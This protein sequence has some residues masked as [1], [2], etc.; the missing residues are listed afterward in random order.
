MGSPADHKQP[1]DHKQA[2]T[3]PAGLLGRVECFRQRSLRPLVA[4]IAMFRRTVHARALPERL[5]KRPRAGCNKRYPSRSSSPCS[6]PFEPELGEKQS[7]L[8]RSGPN[9]ARPLQQRPV[10]RRCCP[11]T[12]QSCQPRPPGVDRLTLLKP[13]PPVNP[14]KVQS[15]RQAAAVVLNPAALRPAPAARTHRRSADR[16]AGPT[17]SDLG[18]APLVPAP[19]ARHCTSVAGGTRVPAP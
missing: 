6:C 9:S 18:E 12:E 11:A 16:L 1:T 13:E 5:P 3:R 15:G 7:A 17:E 8:S 19:T 4:S 10:Q 14:G 2:H